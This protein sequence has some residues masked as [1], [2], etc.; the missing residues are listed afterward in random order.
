MLLSPLRTETGGLFFFL[1]FPY[2]AVSSC[3][4][5]FLSQGNASAR[6]FINTRVGYCQIALCGS[7]KLFLLDIIFLPSCPSVTKALRLHVITP[8]RFRI[9]APPSPPRRGPASAESQRETESSKHL[10]IKI[11]PAVWSDKGRLC[12]A[13]ALHYVLSA[14]ETR[15]DVHFGM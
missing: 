9:K 15:S 14:G 6:R 12:S 3:M 1:C 2:C 11:A 7:R 5:R 13:P 10:C 4:H 8:P